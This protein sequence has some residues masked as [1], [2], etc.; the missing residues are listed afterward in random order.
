MLIGGVHGD[1]L[2]VVGGGSFSGSDPSAPSATAGERRKKERRRTIGISLL[3]HKGHG[4]HRG[5][6]Q[7]PMEQL[8][9][10]GEQQRSLGLAKF[11]GRDSGH[12]QPPSTVC[13]T[14]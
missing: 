5:L 7:P 10:R 6:K 14:V 13:V 3:I 1:W 2:V 11:C 12:L 9:G 8:A 4:V